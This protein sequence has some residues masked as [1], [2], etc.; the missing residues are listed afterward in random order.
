MNR[1]D[2]GGRPLPL[3]E[4]VEAW[5]ARTPETTAVSAPDGDLTFRRLSE[6]V[7]ALAA[8][9]RDGGAGPGTAVGVSYGRSYRQV[10]GV[11]AVLRA[12][13]TLVPLDDRNP[14]DRLS[15][16]LKDAD[17][18]M[19]LGGLPAG[20]SV[21][22][23]RRVTEPDTPPDTAASA[24]EAPLPAAGPDDTAYVIYT[25]GTTGWPKGVEVTYRNLDTFLRALAELG[26][27][28]GGTGINAVSPAFD[29]WLWCILLH[30]LH[31]QGTSII[32][33]NQEAAGDLA[34][35]ISAARPRT[36]CLTPSLLATC[37]DALDG[38]ETLV[39]AGEPCPPGLV[40]RLPDGP[41]VLN[42]YGPTE[43]TIAATWADSARGDDVT[44][45]GRPLTGYHVHILAEDGSPTP[46]G[47][48]GELYVGGPGVARGYRNRPDLTERSFVDDPCA[49]PGARMYRTG[50][51]VSR[52]P[53]GQLRHAGRADEQIKIRG[54]RVELPEVERTAGELPGVRACAAFRTATGDNLGLAVLGG[55]ETAAPEWPARVIDHCA[56]RLPAAVVPTVVITVDALPT[57]PSGKV[58]RAALAR[59]ADEIAARPGGRPARTP[60]ERQVRAAWED[61]LGRSVPDVDADFFA[62][63]GHSLLAARTVSELRR[64]TGLRI[65]VRDLLASPT[66]AGLAAAL[67][68]IAAESGAGGGGTTAVND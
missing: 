57:T 9:L 47:E 30:L 65:S 48:V 3:L 13:A 24:G 67:D 43:T 36:V 50:D 31:G 16:I 39:L 45:I 40:R 41:R 34:E 6:E 19:L 17:V 5:A 35:Q 15:Y 38:V 18:R 25:S 49:G 4:A 12:G 28:P 51:L 26:L 33:L 66:I 42:V 44:T 21:P 58:D 56:T 60:R 29:G 61:V 11:L 20:A 46:P 8:A 32:D 14:A 64:S 59:A 55:P 37:T 7:R 52:L 23:L 63:G 27:P 1:A 53:D 68:R 2:H 10:V 62:L 22:R 54:F